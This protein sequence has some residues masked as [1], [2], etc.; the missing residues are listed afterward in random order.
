MEFAFYFAAGVAVASTLRVITHTNPVHALLYLVVSLLAVSMTFFALGAPFAGVLE[1]IVYAGAIMVLFVFVVMM[2][3]LGPA[4]AEQERAWLKP[5]LWVGP[6]LLSGALL[7]LLLWVLLGSTHS[8]AGIGLTTV[9]AKAVGAHLYGPYLLA[10]ELAS[11]L[12]LAALV[13]AYHL[14]RH[15]AKEP[16]A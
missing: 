10:V 12:L 8:A 6:G 16:T 1:I 14:G 15:D 11:M 13:A 5:G 3:N 7:A 2:L 4:T 9:D